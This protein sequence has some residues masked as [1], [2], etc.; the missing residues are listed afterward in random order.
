VLDEAAIRQAHA[1]R[2][3]SAKEKNSAASLRMWADA[4]VRAQQSAKKRSPENVDRLRQLAR[5][6]STGFWWHPDHGMRHA[7]HGD[8]MSEFGGH[9]S[10]WCNTRAG[11]NT[12]TRGWR[13]VGDD[14][15]TA[16]LRVGE[17]VAADENLKALADK[18]QADRI[19]RKLAAD[20]SKAKRARSALAGAARKAEAARKVADK[21]QKR[22]A[23]ALKKP[24]VEVG[25]RFGRLTVNAR[26]EVRKYPGGG[27]AQMWRVR[28]DCG[29]EKTVNHGSLTRGVTRSCGCLH[30]E[31]SVKNLANTPSARG[32]GSPTRLRLTGQ[33][34]GQL[35]VLRAGRVD[36]RSTY[37][38]VRCDCGVEKEVKG[39]LLTHG[40]VKSCGCLRKVAGK[41]NG[42]SNRGRVFAARRERAA[43]AIIG[44]RFGQ[45]TVTGMQYAGSRGRAIAMCDCGAVCA[46]TPSDLR[47][48]KQLSC[49]CRRRRQA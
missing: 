20:E 29:K 37:W 23:R 2:A 22:Q 40:A 18:K 6:K 24:S 16:Q 42:A 5:D 13:F 45:L 47:A 36:G 14:E 39:A 3:L 11:T 17:I 44:S 19:A 25:S 43:A 4:E 46:A 38:V 30:R 49:G 12:H 8:L 48:G 21:K 7:W 28:C 10:G 1:D 9:N 41:Q 26:E 15:S 31:S 33:R 32:E 27:T 34:F 35:A